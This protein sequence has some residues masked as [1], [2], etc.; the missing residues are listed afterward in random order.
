MKICVGSRS[1]VVANVLDCNLEVN[2]FE[3]QSC[4]YLPFRTNTFQKDKKPLIPGLDSIT[5]VIYKGGFGMN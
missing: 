2:E 5:T 4:C 1:G 3:L